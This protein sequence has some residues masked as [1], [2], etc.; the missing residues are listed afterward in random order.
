[1][2]YHLHPFLLLCCI[3][4]ILHS[5][6][7]KDVDSDDDDNNGG[8]NTSFSITSTS[9][10]PLYWGSELTI[11]GSGFSTNKNDYQLKYISYNNPGCNL[12]NF[13]VIS[14]TSTQLK[15]KMAYGSL[16]NGKKCG[17]S[18]DRLVVTV[19][20]NSDTTNAIN[21]VGWPRIQ[22]VCTHF[23]G[24][25]GEYIIPGDSVMLN[26]AGATGIYASVN[27]NNKNAE[28]TVD[29]IPVPITW[30]NYSGCTNGLGA[31]ITLD[32]AVYGK[33]KCPS[34]ADW[35][36]GGRNMLFKVSNP[37]TNRFDTLSIF[38]NWMPSSTFSQHTGSSNVSMSAGGFPKWTIKGKN[39]TYHKARF[40]ATNC[41]L[42]AQEIA[43]DQAGTFYNEGTFAIPLAILTIGCNYSV[44]IFDH[45]GNQRVLGGVMI[46]P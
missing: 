38:V 43:I 31:V 19:G 41:N 6:E 22:G 45:C 18:S 13:E 40:T 7:K 23:G 39:M 15:V 37:G 20:G 35:G 21:F 30:R 16:S 10:D 9:P 46:T 3:I 28:L 29:G 14:A 5:C 2:K 17:P 8:G 4:P 34:D 12:G 32:K 1:M 11:N 27:N 36:G 42:T 24:W 26:L 44:S 33:L 25:A